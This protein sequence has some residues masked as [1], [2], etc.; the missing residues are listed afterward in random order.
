MCHAQGAGAEYEDLM[1]PHFTKASACVQRM[2]N[3]SYVYFLGSAERDDAEHYGSCYLPTI[4]CF[5][6]WE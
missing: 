4:S 5:N 2:Q 3:I 1:V 6:V